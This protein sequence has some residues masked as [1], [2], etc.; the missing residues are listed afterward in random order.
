MWWIKRNSSVVWV[1]ESANCGRGKGWS[2]EDMISHGFSARHW[3]QMRLAAPLPSPHCCESAT[4]SARRVHRLLDRLDRG[5]Y[6]KTPWVIFSS[7]S[8]HLEMSLWIWQPY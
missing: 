1:R 5:I 7:K 6:H 2:Q 3:Q 8:Q 4:C